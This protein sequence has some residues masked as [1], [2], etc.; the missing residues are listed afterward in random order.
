MGE[1]YKEYLG[2]GRF[3]ENNNNVENK[4]DLKYGVGEN[5]FGLMLKGLQRAFAFQV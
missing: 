3:S 5:K 4:I 1:K 2:L